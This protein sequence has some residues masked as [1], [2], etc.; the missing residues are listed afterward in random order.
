MN[1]PSDYLE[2]INGFDAGW[3]HSLAL[4]VNC[5]V[6]A[7]GN[8][9]QG[10]LGDGGEHLYETTP[11]QVLSGEQDPGNP[12]SFLKYIIAISAGRS[13]EHS[14]AVDA[15]GFV[16]AWGKNVSGECGNGKSGTG[17]KEYTPVLVLDDDPETEDTYLGDIAIIIQVDA[18]VDHSIALDNEGHVWHWGYGSDTE[19]YPEKV[20]DSNGQELSKRILK[21]NLRR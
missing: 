13:G 12:N 1:T 11:I 2:D 4:D 19:T 8:N 7:W 3:K 14:L 18:G 9:Q 15:N 21:L 16:Y 6:W 20:K 5:F 17:E 10:Q